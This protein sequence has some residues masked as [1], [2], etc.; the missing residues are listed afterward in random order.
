MTLFF[1]KNYMKMEF[2]LGFL[3]IV[4]SKVSCKKLGV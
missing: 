2:W 3:F 4:V 1:S